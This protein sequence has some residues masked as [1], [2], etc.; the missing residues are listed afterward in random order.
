MPCTGKRDSMC[1]MQSMLYHAWVLWGRS[2]FWWKAFA[3]PSYRQ[4]SPG[5]PREAPGS[6]T[7]NGAL[8]IYW[9][10]VFEFWSN[11]RDKGRRWYWICKYYSCSISQAGG[12]ESK[13]LS[14][15]SPR[16]WRSPWGLQ[17]YRGLLIKRKRCS[18]F[19]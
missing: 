6:C 18:N 5:K 4:E 9:W 8:Q 19:F 1:E 17:K 10:S 13:L 7:V 15:S 14:H 11:K 3:S 16:N 12:A 2:I